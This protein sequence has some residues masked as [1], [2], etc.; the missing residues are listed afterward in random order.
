[1]L[2]ESQG[3][4]MCFEAPEV[5]ELFSWILHSPKDRE[6]GWASSDELNPA[7]FEVIGRK[8]WYQLRGLYF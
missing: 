4:Q 7:L 5:S 8:P 1:M 6:W 3:R 2:L